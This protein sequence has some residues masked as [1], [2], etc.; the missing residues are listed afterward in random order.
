MYKRLYNFL[1]CYNILNAEQFEFRP[2]HATS[3]ATTLVI[4]NIADAF[5][6]K[7]LT[8][9]VFLDLSK[10]F[11]TIDHDILLYKLNYYGI[12]GTAVESFKSYLSGRTQQVQFNNCLSSTIKPI[13]SSVPQGS[14]LGPLLFILYVNDF[15]NCLDFSTNV[16]FADDTNIFIT[17]KNIQ[18]V[19]SKT[20]L[21][22]KNIDE[23]MTAKKLT[24]NSAKTKYL[25]FTPRK[26]NY[27]VSN[28]SFEVHFRNNTIEKV[29][30][31][32]F[33]GVIINENL[34]WKE[35][36]NTIKRKIRSSLGSIMRVKPCLTT[37]AM[38][39]LYNSLLLSHLRFCITSWC[40][41]NRT[42]INQL[43]RICNK[44]IRAMYGIKRRGC[45]KNV[46]IK[47]ELLNIQQ[48]Y[49]SE[50]AILMYKFQKRTLPIPIQHYFSLNHVKLKLEVIVKLF[51]RVL[52]QQSANNQLNLLDPKF[53]I[54]CLKK[55]KT[56]LH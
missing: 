9:A 13:T 43:Q 28:T 6:K 41:G 38:L 19:Y 3:H 10:A 34:S 37:K 45:V 25:L 4:S 12:R 15:R 46:M 50:I 42:K 40:F 56:A 1:K 33:L 36:M 53:E 22:L 54:L 55:L 18:S 31:I 2:G 39:I 20:N 29:S 11:D 49:E 52:E 21:E 8:I 47:N 30:S 26:S 17:G 48:L 14:I 32:R 5:E 7:L 27:S 16:S 23:W 51:L 35:H 24:V 44:F